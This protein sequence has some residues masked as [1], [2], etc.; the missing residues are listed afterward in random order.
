MVRKDSQVRQYGPASDEVFS[1]EVME[2]GEEKEF[3][4]P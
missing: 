4:N 1:F 3:Y 2:C